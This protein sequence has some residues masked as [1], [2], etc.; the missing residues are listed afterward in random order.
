MSELER[1]LADLIAGLA[2][3]QSEPIDGE[4]SPLWKTVCD[5]GL[6]G[7]GL[8]ED[9]G[10][11]GGDFTDL[12]TVITELA[13]AGIPTPIAEASTA[14]AALQQPPTAT[15]FAIVAVAPTAAVLDGQRLTGEIPDVGY[16]ALAARLVIVLGDVNRVVV[17]D[18]NAEGSSHQ[19]V[20]DLAGRPTSTLRFDHTPIHPLAPSV[21]TE[22]VLARIGI[23]RTAEIVGHARAAYD[24][25]RSYVR[26][27][28]QFGAPLADVPAVAAGLAQM[29]IQVRQCQSALHRAA[30]IYVSEAADQQA[31]RRAAAV[32]R[33][34]SAEV[35]TAT[36]Q[37]AHQL[38][39]AVGVTREYPLHRHTRAL[40]SGRDADEPVRNHSAALGHVAVAAGQD[41][42]WEELTA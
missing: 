23:C 21:N 37:L 30:R 15:G 5:L 32:S 35:A 22:G 9:A 10:G 1:E 18:S 26:Q 31:K 42:L 3:Q 12:L 41:V 17:V 19:H 13:Y 39:G 4:L 2:T 20:T 11:S 7:V 27:R 14:A 29:A 34:I 6:A 40:W 8:S 16:G 28:E 36:A 38:H 24:L 25:T 33:C